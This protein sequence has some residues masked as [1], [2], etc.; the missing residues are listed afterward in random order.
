VTIRSKGLEA[1]QLSNDVKYN[2]FNF[3]ETIPLM[4][5]TPFRRDRNWPDIRLT[6]KLVAGHPA[7]LNT[8]VLSLHFENYKPS[9]SSDNNE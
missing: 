9:K 2:I 7:K 4:P 8:K 1:L 3:R 6:K 5:N